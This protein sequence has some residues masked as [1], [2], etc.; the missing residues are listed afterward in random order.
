MPKFIKLFDFF[1]Q[2]LVFTYKGKK[3]IKTEWGGLFSI[4]AFIIILFN[5]YLIGRD[6]F[7]RENP[8]SLKYVETDKVTPTRRINYNRNLLMYE[9]TD[10][11]NELFWDETIMQLKP[12]IYVAKQNKKGVFIYREYELEMVDCQT[13][14]KNITQIQ[15]TDDELQTFAKNKKCIKNFDSYL[16]GDW[17]DEFIIHFMMRLE[18]CRNTTIEEKKKI[19][20]NA[21]TDEENEFLDEFEK[22]IHNLHYN[23]YD[24]VTQFSD[25]N[26][27]LYDYLQKYQKEK[28]YKEIICK[29]QS[30]IEEQSKNKWLIYYLNSIESNPVNYPNP[31]NFKVSCFWGI[32]GNEFYKRFS[33]YYDNFVSYTDTGYIFQDYNVDDSRIGFSK[34]NSDFNLK[35]PTDKL[36]YSIEYYV[37][38]KF[39]INSRNYIKLQSISAYMGGIMSLILSVFRIFSIPFFDKKLNLKVMNE[40]FD[41]DSMEEL[42]NEKNVKIPKNIELKNTIKKEADFKEKDKDNYFKKEIHTEKNINELRNFENKIEP[43]EIKEQYFSIKNMNKNSGFLLNDKSCSPIN[44]SDNNISK[45]NDFEAKNI[46]NDKSQI[47]A[48]EHLNFQENNKILD[49]K[50]EKKINQIYKILMNKMKFSNF[51]IFR[52]SYFLTCFNKKLTKK[53]TAYNLAVKDI[54][55]GTDY[56]EIIKLNRNFKIMQ[57][58]LLENQQIKCF[59]FISNPKRYEDGYNH[60]IKDYAEI[61]MPK[62]IMKENIFKIHEHFERKIENKEMNIIDNR[63]WG[64]FN[65]KIKNLFDHVEQ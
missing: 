18:S 3:V 31:L 17:T 45:I 34:M 14:L 57:Y 4:I 6:I 22:N 42:E 64:I 35:E 13:G 37:T 7:Q 41:F 51:E 58:L 10:F 38:T 16:G 30:I 1:P 55:K 11:D 19:Y 32:I 12:I 48:G 25:G 61:F 46:I 27:I 9:I 52:T 50:V 65:H 53:K 62:L 26:L 15:F 21:E 8:T 28:E 59:P 49:P 60:D 39:F 5:T 23:R 40:L 33:F 56:L 20:T 43:I 29:P 44:K 2:R 63:I 36:L 24:H 54:H 47:P